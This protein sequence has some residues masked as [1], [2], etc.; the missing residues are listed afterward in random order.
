MALVSDEQLQAFLTRFVQQCQT[1]WPGFETITAGSALQYQVSTLTPVFDHLVPNVLMADV[2]TVALRWTNRIFDR[3][4]FTIESVLV[5]Q[6]PFLSARRAILGLLVLVVRLMRLAVASTNMSIFRRL[7]VV[8]ALKSFAEWMVGNLKDNHLL[9]L[10]VQAFQTFKSA[11]QSIYVGASLTQSL[12]QSNVKLKELDEFNALRGGDSIFE[13]VEYIITTFLPK[14]FAVNQIQTWFERGVQLFVI[15][16]S[17]FYGMVPYAAQMND[18][19]GMEYWKKFAFVFREADATANQQ[20]N[21]KAAY[22]FLKLCTSNVQNKVAGL[23][24]T[25]MVHTLRVSFPV[26]HD[27]YFPGRGMVRS[28]SPVSVLMDAFDDAEPPTK[29]GGLR[30]RISAPARVQG[31]ENDEYAPPFQ[32][33]LK[34]WTAASRQRRNEQLACIEAQHGAAMAKRCRRAL[35]RNS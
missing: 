31:G 3:K 8:F 34:A 26:V 32:P 28:L 23:T 4:E 22:Q 2:E 20:A 35:A 29:D 27:Q 9:G 18:A 10:S 14:F 12:T 1:V 24:S 13:N 21:Q 16:L 33:N 7:V 6:T 11:L 15:G 19:P 5:N 25:L 30:H 17:L